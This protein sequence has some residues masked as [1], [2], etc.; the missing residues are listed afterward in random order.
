MNLALALLLLCTLAFFHMSS[1][2]QIASHRVN[3]LLESSRRG[4]RPARDE[5]DLV[6]L[7]D[8]DSRANASSSQIVDDVTMGLWGLRPAVVIS[9]TA[10]EGYLRA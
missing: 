3:E 5:C 7:E 4:H 6:I 1:S 8:E 2:S 9:R 10:A